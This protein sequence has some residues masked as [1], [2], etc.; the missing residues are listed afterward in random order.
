[1]ILCLGATSIDQKSCLLERRI[2]LFNQRHYIFNKQQ[3]NGRN[4]K[5]G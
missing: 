5:K 4:E 1:M 2:L 3:R